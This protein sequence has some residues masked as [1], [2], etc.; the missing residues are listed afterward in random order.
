MIL[1]I[2]HKEDFTADIVINKLNQG[3]HKYFRLNTEDILNPNQFLISFDGDELFHSLNGI[4]SFSSVWF[5]RVMLPVIE[6]QSKPKKDFLKNEVYALFSNLWEIIDARWMSIPHNVYRA[7]NKLLQLRHAQTIGFNIPKTLLTIS[8]EKIREFYDDCENKIIIKPLMNSHI[9]TEDG[10][11]QA[12][13]SNLLKK[14][15]LDALEEFAPMPFILQKYIEKKDEVRVTVVHE[16]VFAAAVDSQA[17]LDSSIDWRRKPSKFV[18]IQLPV[19]IEDK[20]L[21]IVRNLNLEFGAIDLIRTPSGNYVFLEINPN[22]QWGWIEFDT[23][24]QIS[25]AVVEFLISK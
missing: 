5:R 15:D 12:I 2:T 10:S 1:V 17:S 20:C 24:M 18:Q 7:E 19:E 22:G 14:E 6:G 21:R 23:G 11:D 8:N 13:F 4:E 3:G 9:M 16:K 25:D